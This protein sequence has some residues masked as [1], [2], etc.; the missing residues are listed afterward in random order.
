[1]LFPLFYMYYMW[2]CMFQNGAQ[3]YIADRGPMFS[4]AQTFGFFSPK[5][6]QKTSYNYF[7]APRMP[8]LAI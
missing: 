6:E 8:F 7:S 4:P 5:Y 1:M 2:M 3:D